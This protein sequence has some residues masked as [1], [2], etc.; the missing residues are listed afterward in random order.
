MALAAVL[1]AGGCTGGGEPAEEQG[2]QAPADVSIPGMEPVELIGP[3]EEGAGEVPVFEWQP[4]EGA[5]TY[6]LWVLNAES[7][8][9]WAWEGEETSV[10]L[11]GLDADRPE[12]HP[13]PVI[14][15]GST[16]TVSALDAESHAVALS[17][18]RPV[19]P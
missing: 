19:T 15:P 4:V 1:A 16:W 6:R 7:D 8:P 17:P 10:R 18:R 14:T 3:P 5:A 12:G 13:G 9:I 11:G 2:E